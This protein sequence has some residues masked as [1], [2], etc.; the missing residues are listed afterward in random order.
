ML[1]C[2]KE[3]KKPE[4]TYLTAAKPPKN[5]L[6]TSHFISSSLATLAGIIVAV[7]P[8]VENIIVRKFP[9]TK[10]DMRD[11]GEIVITICGM[12]AAGGSGY[13]LY[14]RAVN[15]QKVYTPRGIFGSNVEDL[16]EEYE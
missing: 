15:Q 7:Y 16:L 14:D 11:I 13:A 12:F 4:N 9:V 2:I 10:E 5:Y 6:K 1:P 8:N 3:R